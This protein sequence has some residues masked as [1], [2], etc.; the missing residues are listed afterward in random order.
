[1][2]LITLELARIILAE[3]SLSFLGLGIQ[4]PQSSWGLMIADGRNY[5]T[6]AWWLVTFPGI[7]IAV[8]VFGVMT[9]ANWLRTVTDP[10]QRVRTTP[11]GTGSG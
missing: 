4:P 9:V 1:L 5:I 10:E 7:C 2:T 6:V 3:A 8:T 11:A